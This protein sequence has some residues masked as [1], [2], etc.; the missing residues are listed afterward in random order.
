MILSRVV[1]C[2]ALCLV[3][4]GECCSRQCCRFGWPPFCFLQGYPAV[5]IG[6][7]AKASKVEEL[8][9]VSAKP[10]QILVDASSRHLAKPAGIVEGTREGAL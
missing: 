10:L 4:L 1:A 3:C 8:F 9:R 6:L 5:E 2:K 7:D